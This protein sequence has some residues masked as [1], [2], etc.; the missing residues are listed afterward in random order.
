MTATSYTDTDLTDGTTYYYVVAAV[1]AAGSSADSTQ[2]D[3]V[4]SPAAPTGL[5]ATPGPLQVSLTW[6]ASAGATSYNV[7]RSTTSGGGYATV[8]SGL[9]ATSYTDTAVSYGATYYYVVSAANAASESPASDEIPA[10]PAS[11]LLSETESATPAFVI[12]PSSGETPA[13]ARLTTATSVV[14]H[15][16]QLQTS[17]DLAS[18]SWLAVGDPVLG[19]GSPIVFETPYDPAEPRRFYRILVTR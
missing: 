7:K 4:T 13:M 8:A 6:S 17:T 15:S 11:A 10:T 5:A 18:G 2:V 1:N 14:G 19:D 12:I 16:Y 3:A 9:T